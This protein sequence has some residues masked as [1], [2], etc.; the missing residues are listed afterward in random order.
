[1][2]KKVFFGFLL[3]TVISAYCFA[4][5]VEDK[6]Q[7]E[8][9]RKELQ[10]EL[11]EIQG[12]YDKVKGQ[13]KQTLGQLSVLNRKINLQEKYISS[14][15]KEIR[16]IDD[17]IYL[18]NLE[19]Y[20][21]QKQM[22][23][24]KAQY[25]KTVVYAYTNRSSYDYLNFIFSANSFNDAI[26]RVAYLKSYRE[27]RQ[28]QVANIIETQQMISQRKQQQ[29]GRKEQK[30]VALENQTKQVDELA[31]QKKEKD[32]VVSKLKTQE[33][34]LQ[35]QIAAKKKRDRDLQ[36]SINVIV[37][38]EIEAAKKEAAKRAADE[39]KKNAGTN[40]ST[41]TNPTTVVNPTSRIKATTEKPTVIFN[42]DADIK[43]NAGFETNRGR[44]PWPVDNGYL[45]IRFGKYE[46][47]GTKLVGD[48]PG[49]TIG[50]QAGNTV[51]SVFDGEVV[52]IFNMGDGMAV[53]VRHGRY[54]T[55]Y[56]NLTGVS[57]SKG[58]N[59]KT[60]QALGRAGK[61]DEGSSGQIDFILMI[62]TKNVNPE[63]WLRR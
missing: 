49:I 39:A 41:N 45:K 4:Q 31:K 52:A 19:I 9:E 11:S 18:S 3:T 30:N 60:G 59:V 14:I 56:S 33:K 15:N 53:T 55:T 44:L 38:R 23:T 43:L 17:D 7:L 16:S 47:E 40:P 42:S 57:I 8:K 48:N 51:K 5:P 46:I 2:K 34:D 54:F 63:P 24:L 36:N 29:V 6:A 13:T 20:R 35:K 10:K 1:M 12:L 27:Y 28:K 50:T 32:A 61:D 21:L 25:A 37:R 22:D 26:R 58:A 62:E